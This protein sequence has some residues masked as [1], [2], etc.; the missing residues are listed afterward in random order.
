MSCVPPGAGVHH[1][2]LATPLHIWQ[3]QQHLQAHRRMQ[4]MHRMY[5]KRGEWS[6]LT[7][8]EKLCKELGHVCICS[9][10]QGYIKDMCMHAATTWLVHS[11]TQHTKWRPLKDCNLI[12]KREKHE[13]STSSMCQQG[14]TNR[15]QWVSGIALLTLFLG[16][17][18]D[19]HLQLWCL[20]C[21]PHGGM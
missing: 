1:G 2:P 11:D 17:V 10:Q 6:M 18:C 16:A 15:D 14:N 20:A 5:S 13:G 21:A 4:C 19:V 3:P 8:F 7:S 12:G 9:K